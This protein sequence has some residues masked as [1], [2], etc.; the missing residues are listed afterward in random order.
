MDVSLAVVLS[1]MLRQ[2]P[3]RIP[4]RNS[5]AALAAAAEAGNPRNPVAEAMRMLEADHSFQE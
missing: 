2:L 5:T 4:A 1:V 3:C